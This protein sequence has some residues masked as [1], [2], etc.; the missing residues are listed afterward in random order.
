MDR[1]YEMVKADNIAEWESNSRV[2][3]SEAVLKRLAQVQQVN[4]KATSGD[5]R[6]KTEIMPWTT[7]IRGAGNG[8]H[9]PPKPSSPTD[10]T[11]KPN[12]EETGT[13]DK[14]EKTKKQF[15]KDWKRVGIAQLKSGAPFKKLAQ[16]HQFKFEDTIH[17]P[18]TKT[19]TM[20][21][22]K[23]LNAEDEKMIDPFDITSK[24]AK[25]KP[26][27]PETSKAVSDTAGGGLFEKHKADA[28]RDWEELCKTTTSP[29]ALRKQA[30]IMQVKL[31]GTTR[32][33]RAKTEPMPWDKFIP[34]KLSA[35]HPPQP[36]IK[37]YAE[38]KLERQKGLAPN[39]KADAVVDKLLGKEPADPAAEAELLRYGKVVD[40]YISKWN[41]MC[42][43]HPGVSRRVLAKK[44]QKGFVTKAGGERVKAEQM[45]WAKYLDGG[46]GVAAPAPTLAAAP[47]PQKPVQRASNLGPDEKCAKL[48]ADCI[49]QWNAE[50]GSISSDEAKRKLAQ[51]HQVK[52][53]HSHDGDR[54]MTEMPWTRYLRAG[55]TTKSIFTE[56]PNADPPNPQPPTSQTEKLSKETATRTAPVPPLT[57]D[58][59]Y[60]K[61]KAAFV[62]EW[63]SMSGRANGP[64]VLHKLAKKIQ[65]RFKHS[66][67][68]PPGQTETMPWSKYLVLPLEDK[69]ETPPGHKTSSSG[70]QEDDSPSP[71]P[72]LSKMNT[73]K[74]D[75]FMLPTVESE[76]PRSR[77]NSNPG[78]SIQPVLS[79]VPSTKNISSESSAPPHAK[80]P[81]AAVGMSGIQ[82]K[83]LKDRFE[84]NW[85]VQ[86]RKCTGRDYP[87]LAKATQ[88]SFAKAAGNSARSRTEVMLWTKYLNTEEAHPRPSSP[89]VSHAPSTESKRS[90]AQKSQFDKL[91]AKFE[92]GWLLMQEK[93]WQEKDAYWSTPARN[94]QNAFEEETGDERAKTEVMP[95]SRYLAFEGKEKSPPSSPFVEEPAEA[96]PDQPS[97]PSMPAY[98][99]LKARFT[100]TWELRKEGLGEDEYDKLATAIQKA[101]EK[102]ANNEE[103]K[104]EIMPWTMYIP[105]TYVLE[106]F[107]QPRKASI[108]HKPWSQIIPDAA[109]IPPTPMPETRP[110]PGPGPGSDEKYQKAV[111]LFECRWDSLLEERKGESRVPLAKNM[112]KNFETKAADDRANP[113]PMPWTKYLGRNG[114]VEQTTFGAPEP[115]EA[116]VPI[117]DEYRG[118]LSA[119]RDIPTPAPTQTRPPPLKPTWEQPSQRPKPPANKQPVHP[120]VQLS[121]YEKDK[122]YFIADWPKTPDKFPGMPIPELAGKIQRAFERTS[123]DER[124]KTERMPWSEHLEDW[125]LRAPASEAYDMRPKKEVKKPE[126]PKLDPEVMERYKLPLRR[127]KVSKPGYPRDLPVGQPEKPTANAV[128]NP[129]TQDDAYETEKKT[130]RKAWGRLCGAVDMGNM[131][132]DWS[133]HASVFQ[134]NFER[135]RKDS[136]AAAE[137]MPW[138]VYLLKEHAKPA[139]ASKPTAPADMYRTT[140]K[141]EKPRTQFHQRRAVLVPVDIYGAAQAPLHSVPAKLSTPIEQDEKYQECKANA[142]NAWNQKIKNHPD[143]D[144]VRLAGLAHRFQGVFERQTGRIGYVERGNSEYLP[145]TDLLPVPSV[146][147]EA[148]GHVSA[149]KPTNTHSHV[150]DHPP[151]KIAGTKPSPSGGEPFIMYEDE[152]EYEREKRYHA[153]RW[154]NR[155]QKVKEGRD[156]NDWYEHARQFQKSFEKITQ[157]LRAMNEAMPWGKYLG[158]GKDDYG[159]GMEPRS[160]KFKEKMRREERWSAR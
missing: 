136:R 6:A 89:T 143:M 154:G 79:P 31:E 8:V 130:Q 138:S 86:K 142:I 55:S 2:S 38:A 146:E 159:R 22:A 52:F 108:E 112:Q 73:N 21:W 141:K 76:P 3:T 147:T 25:S 88:D 91:K 126:P 17:D 14:Y 129:G 13:V 32:D 46:A 75:S 80:S 37:S 18:R 127:E 35:S 113:E 107:I 137:I 9:E 53:E 158:K 19:E 24:P 33:E 40:L 131:D 78:G 144:Q 28:I 51:V 64:L 95:W 16:N 72:D 10:D 58:Q 67:D 5:E 120:L 135:R 41:S 57:P 155:I 110:Q 153:W 71:R 66:T 125:Y 106:E 97:A 23:Y 116:R 100:T 39:P 26:A 61:H 29:A 68:D 1:K 65:L 63:Q 43:D 132:K 48:K 133:K 122:R 94:V 105:A 49:T 119:Y 62:E 118:L 36:P 42:E 50:S 47:M 84:I 20:P 114:V 96:V 30:Q 128:N 148:E 44:I 160:E 12:T 99:T 104:E 34:A 124:A 82:S 145:W 69:S 111:A 150:N 70:P 7:Y 77:L 87:A 102:A 156:H 81:K 101:F 123:R 117:V 85:D 149:S 83:M 157:D 121:R 60:A 90:R 56:P 98:E 152:S 103:A 92:M 109:P 59:A 140:N 27:K 134:R 151:R 45:P 139:I 115:R 11:S 4:F 15:L 54:S 93:H 74:K